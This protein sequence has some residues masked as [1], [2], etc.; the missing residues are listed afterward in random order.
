MS[1]SGSCQSSQKA[2]LGIS[3]KRVKASLIGHPVFQNLIRP[4]QDTDV[5]GLQTRRKTVG[6]IIR[7]IAWH[8]GEVVSEHC[9]SAVAA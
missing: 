8:G 7:A 4:C 5:S 1:G 3:R 2:N 6:R 9:L